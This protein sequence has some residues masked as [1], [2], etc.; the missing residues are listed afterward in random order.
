VLPFGEPDNNV[1]TRNVAMA[2]E[3]LRRHGI[4]VTAQRTGGQTGLF[5]RFA[6]DT[7][8]VLVRAIA[9]VAGPRRV[10]LSSG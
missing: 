4:R 1:G 3:R 2:T 9:P 5:I 7:G 6:S 8:D 10:R